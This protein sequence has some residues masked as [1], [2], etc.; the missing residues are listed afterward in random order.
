MNAFGYVRLSKW[1]DNTTSPQRQR[2]AIAQLCKQ[3]G[4]KLVEV[5]ED[6]D[7]S[8]Y[9]GNHRP[10]FERMMAQLGDTDAI[11]FPTLDRLSRSTAQAGRIAEA[12]KAAGVHMVATD[13]PIDTTS[14][15]GKFVYDVL[16]AKGEMESSTIS[17]RSR[18]MVAWKKEQGEPLGRVPFGWRRVGK[19]FEKDPKQQATLE[20]AA[21]RYVAGGTFNGIAKSLGM[22]TGP[23]S[24]MLHSQR[25]RDALPPD[26]AGALAAAIVSR[27]RERVPTSM[28]SL[29]GGIATCGECGNTMSTTSTRG[30]R[31]GRWFS[32]GCRTAGHVHISAPW[33]DE[34]VTSQV[35]AAVD[36]GELLK[37]LKRRKP[38]ARTRKASEVEARMAL[39]DE[40]FTS[41]KVTA[42]RFKR[43][44]AKL[45]EELGKA[46]KV[47]RE[48]GH[49]L[50]EELARD[51]SK[52]W[53]QLTVGEKRRVIQA[54]L[55]KIVVT[56]AKAHGPI[57]DRRVK[58]VWR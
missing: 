7:V 57:D 27:K 44:N 51:L 2:K 29:L 45:V 40:Q 13:M 25:V 47:E 53:P 15:G 4:W 35:L 58:L 56:K 3:R 50:P 20:K 14:A 17:E 26:L 24:R 28:Q 10:Q 32:Y 33:L 41:G 6:I 9:N 23:L 19:H 11:V 46:T 5:F 52:S 55:A 8:A 1:G 18:A 12:C 34:F 54:V 38:I 39:L 30:G 37:A 43:M 36:S 42:E 31:S 21:R 49:D 22:Q 16:A 48:N